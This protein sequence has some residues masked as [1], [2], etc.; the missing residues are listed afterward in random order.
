MQAMKVRQRVSLPF[1]IRRG[2]VFGDATLDW[3]F[4]AA[5]ILAEE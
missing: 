4:A 5:N 1:G 3:L 2:F